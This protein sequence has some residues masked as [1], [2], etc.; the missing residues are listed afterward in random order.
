M[1]LCDQGWK[2]VGCTTDDYLRCIDF[3]IKK[4][5]NPN[6]K[7]ARGNTGLHKAIGSQNM[8]TVRHFIDGAG[9]RN[10]RRGEFSIGAF[11]WNI[12]NNDDWNVLNMAVG[13][14]GAQGKCKVIREMMYDMQRRGYIDRHIPTSFVS[15]AR[16]RARDG[17]I[18]DKRLER[19]A[20]RKQCLSGWKGHR[21][22]R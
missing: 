12:K 4:G 13:R 9:S 1:V 15:S 11:D 8:A 19:Q 2:A 6:A 20:Q 21:P 17:P 14:P 22:F 18:P 5:A 10:Q 3:M 7:D 16:K